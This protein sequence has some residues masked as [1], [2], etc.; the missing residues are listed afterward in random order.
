MR[1]MTILVPAI[2]GASSIF[3]ASLRGDKQDENAATI[4]MRIGC[5]CGDEGRRA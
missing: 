5:W 4:K 1:K 3:L 2:A